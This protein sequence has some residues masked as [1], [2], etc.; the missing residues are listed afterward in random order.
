MDDLTKDRPIPTQE[1]LIR[2]ERNNNVIQRLSRKLNSYTCEPTNYSCFEKLR[3]L[4]HDFK[5]FAGNQKQLVQM[6]KKERKMGESLKTEINK[7][8][9]LFKRLESE[10]A[11][12]LLDTN[13][14]Y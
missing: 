10:M 2:L 5:T 13:Q 1:L 3:D 4:K 7:H 6:V 8:I 9:E 12:Y 11:A 14:Y